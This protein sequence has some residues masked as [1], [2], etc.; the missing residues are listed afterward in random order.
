[1]MGFAWGMSGVSVPFTG[2]LADRIGIERTMMAIA[3]VPLMAAALAW[4]LPAGR[5]LRAP[6]RAS[7]NVVPEVAGTDV[8]E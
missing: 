2:L 1:M 8:A 6:A 4:P 5:R 7:E 3:C